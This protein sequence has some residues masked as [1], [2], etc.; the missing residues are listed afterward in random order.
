MTLSSCKLRVHTLFVPVFKVLRSYMDWPLSIFLNL[1]A[2]IL[3]P[4]LFKSFALNC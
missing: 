3:D 1:F 4:H 2:P